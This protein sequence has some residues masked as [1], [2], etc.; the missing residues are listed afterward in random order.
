MVQLQKSG[1]N[2]SFSGRAEIRELEFMEPDWNA[3]GFPSDRL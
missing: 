2:H 1:R 3:P